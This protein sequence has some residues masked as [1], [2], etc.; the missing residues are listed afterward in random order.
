MAINA[1]LSWGKPTIEVRTAGSNGTYTT[2]PTPMEGTTEL[3][4]EKGDKMEAK[5]EG[6]ENEAVKYKR[7]TY[8][9]VFNI[10]KALGRTL[11]FAIDDGLVSGTYEFKLTPED[12]TAPGFIL[13]VG[14]VSI[15]E[16]WSAED[17]GVWEI[18]VDA[19]RPDDGS[20][21]ITWTDDTEYYRESFIYT[22]VSDPTGNPK[23]LGY[24]E[25]SGTIGNYTFAITTD[26]TVN[27]EKTY[28]TRT[29]V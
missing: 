18:T 26:T 17:G 20:E 21:T 7:N 8:T 16:T 15:N 14:V 5:I 22:A 25:R 12:P 13:H 3:Q 28:Y 1:V 4:S 29:T 2:L 27:G 9:L 10:R 19:L 23:T 6:G 24:Y 11:P